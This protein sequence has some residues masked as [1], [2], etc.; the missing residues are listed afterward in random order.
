MLQVNFLHVF[1]H[2]RPQLPGSK[3]ILELLP[4]G[5]KSVSHGASFQFSCSQEWP[6]KPLRREEKG[7]SCVYLALSSAPTRPPS[8]PY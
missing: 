7:D 2:P 6:E 4:F 8:T 3:V 1:P 5:R